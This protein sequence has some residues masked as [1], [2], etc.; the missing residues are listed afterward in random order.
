MNAP[1]A[2][3]AYTIHEAK[4]H[5][6]RLIKAALAGEEVIITRG[7]EP[8]A[9][10]VPL[11]TELPPRKPGAWKGKVHYTEETFEPWTPDDLGNWSEKPL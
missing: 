11:E 8:V 9:K 3:K 1:F 4:T 2:K 10:L 5:L 6:S 7:K